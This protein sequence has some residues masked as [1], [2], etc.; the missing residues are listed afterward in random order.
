MKM[1]N[2]TLEGAIALAAQLHMGQRDKAGACYI[3]HPLR[4]MLDPILKTEE[5]RI[6]AVLHDVVEDCNISPIQ[7]RE[8]GYSETVV[9][10]LFFL[11]KLPE[12][13]NNYAAFIE[14]ICTGSSSIARKVKIADL[15]D[16]ADLS[17]FENPTE[18]DI[19]RQEKYCR[20]IVRLETAL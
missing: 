4:V 15:R 3:L 12:E 8:L 2:C 5:E 10:A 13:K 16:N 9:E 19:Q 1:K 11:T 20:A 14:R 17:R 6:V 7:L 18:K